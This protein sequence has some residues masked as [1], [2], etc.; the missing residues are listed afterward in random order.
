MKR[1]TCTCLL[2]GLVFVLL[3]GCAIRRGVVHEVD[4]GE[5]LWRIAQVYDVKLDTLMEVNDI[6]NARRVKV[7]TQIVI[8]GVA[9]VRDVPGS[10]QRRIARRA[11]GGLTS[12]ASDDASYNSSSTASQPSGRSSSTE[13]KNSSS[14][15]P[16]DP[17]NDTPEGSSSRIDPS[18]NAPNTSGENGVY[19]DPAWPCEG[20]LASRFDK[21]SGPTKRGI[22]IHT[23]SG[24]VVKAA[25]EGNIKLAGEWEKMPDLGKI[26]IIFHSND[27]TTVYAH[28]K[29]VKV[30]EGTKVERGQPIGT[31]GRSGDVNQPMCYFEVRYKLEPRDPLI[32]L[33]EPS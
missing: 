11:D 3:V 12:D 24:S 21:K 10:P 15:V 18:G 29:S 22:R 33:G 14:S 31:V 28:L 5:T 9:E 2:I 19:F 20:R 17:R 7:G 16:S 27:F 30:S 26:V 25:D 32:F 4:R 13:P 1:L 23:S 8:P 6:E